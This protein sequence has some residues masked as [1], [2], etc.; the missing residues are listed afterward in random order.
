M[1]KKA[2]LILKPRE[3]FKKSSLPH[4]VREQTWNHYIGSKHGEANCFC[5]EKN[6]ITPFRFECAHIIADVMG[7]SSHIDNLLPCCSQCNR[8]MGIMNFF[9]F[10]SKLLNNPHYNKN[11]M[12]DEQ[13]SVIDFYNYKQEHLTCKEY[14]LNFNDWFDIIGENM[15]LQIYTK[16]DICINKIECDCGFKFEYVTKKDGDF[17][18]TC[19][20]TN[21]NI[22]DVIC[23][24]IPCMIHKIK[25][26]RKTQISNC[27]KKWKNDN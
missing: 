3:I 13:K 17:E 5:C 26:I 16:K 6:I 15:H 2:C 25:F 23:D 21:Q 9:V 4:V 10:K 11:N 8:S 22:I 7:G 20:N 27:Y 1:F 14:L 19:K 24:H 18:L 12:S